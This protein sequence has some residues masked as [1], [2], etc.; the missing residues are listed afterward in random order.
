MGMEY[1]CCCAAISL[2]NTAIALM[3]RHEHCLSYETLKDALELIA[4]GDKQPIDSRVVEADHETVQE[5]LNRA[6]RILSSSTRPLNRI[7]KGADV[8]LI[9]VAPTT[10]APSL[11]M[12]TAA[13]SRGSSCYNSY[14]LRVSPIRIEPID[15]ESIRKLSNQLQVKAIMLYNYSLC[16]NCAWRSMLGYRH[17]EFEGPRRA[18]RHSI[19]V[20]VLREAANIVSTLCLDVFAGAGNSKSTVDPGKTLPIAVVIYSAYMQAL[21]DAGVLAEAVECSAKIMHLNRA[22][23]SAFGGCIVHPNRSTASAA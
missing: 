13:S 6:S 9:V 15:A 17:G 3:E 16:L 5:K 11:D 12:L 4:E 7:A 14:P 18:G 1:F 19:R 8:P 22:L 21:E 2:N 10:D 20:N 23:V